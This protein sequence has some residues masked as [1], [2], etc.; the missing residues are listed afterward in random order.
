MIESTSLRITYIQI[1]QHLQH[2]ARDPAA[3]LSAYC[4]FFGAFNLVGGLTT[5]Q[6]M[7]SSSV[8]VVMTL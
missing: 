1:E 2:Y 4:P 7:P 3:F 5:K 6:A 8:I